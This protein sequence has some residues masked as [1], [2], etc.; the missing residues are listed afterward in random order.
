MAHTNDHKSHDLF[1]KI[2]ILSLVVTIAAMS[3]LGMLRIVEQLRPGV[4]DAIS[5]RPTQIVSHGMEPRIEVK[6]ADKSGV[7]SCVLD[8]RR[9]QQSTGSLI[10][11]ARRPDP[12][13]TYRVHWAGGPTSGAR[14][15]CG[16]SAELLLSQVQFTTLKMAATL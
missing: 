14:T 1:T 8:V 9:M 15:N 3:I 4:G 12:I 11:E 2:S 10:I 13:L 6:S 16:A 5:F 7:A